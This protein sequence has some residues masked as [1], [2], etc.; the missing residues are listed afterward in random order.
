M[1]EI[2]D[3]LTLAGIFIALGLVYFGLKSQV[4]LIKHQ[5]L[6]FRE[7]NQPLR[8]NCLLTRK[9]IA[10]ECGAEAKNS[11]WSIENIAL[12]ILKKHGYEAHLILRTTIDERKKGLHYLSNT[13]GV[14]LDKNQIL[15]QAIAFAEA[16]Y[17][18]T[19]QST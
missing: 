3:T 15:D 6:V 12:R 17:L 4:P 7:N 8:P 2:V 1:S 10:I 14:F 19:L 9:P 13:N 18:N 5:W 11:F 16:D